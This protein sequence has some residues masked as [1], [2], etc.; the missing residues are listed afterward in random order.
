MPDYKTK[1]RNSAAFH[2]PTSMIHTV[3]GRCGTR[4]LSTYLLLRFTQLLEGAELGGFPSIYFYDSHS[5]W[6]V[7]NSA[8]FH[9]STSTIHTVAGRCGTPPL[10]TY[11]LLRFTQLLEGLELRRFPPIY[12]YDSHSC[13]AVPSMLVFR[14]LLMIT[15]LFLMTRFLSQLPTGATCL[16][17]RKKHLEDCLCM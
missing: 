1:V 7:R 5:C 9:L 17:S 4:R 3:A 2:L 6:K 14:V 13:S 12:F 10:S 8:A 15:V 16:C 11:L